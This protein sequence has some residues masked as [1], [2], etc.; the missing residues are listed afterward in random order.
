M[1]RMTFCTLALLALFTVGMAKG[2][3][4]KKKTAIDKHHN[5]ATIVKVDAKQSTVT[6]KMKDPKGKVAEKT[7]PLTLGAAYLNSDGT[8]AKLDAF[9]PG[10]HVRFTE[11]DGKIL[12]MKKRLKRTHATISK[13]DAKQGTV[14]LTMQDQGGKEASKTFAVANETV[15]LD[16]K[17]NA[18]KLDTFHMGDRVRISETHNEIVE[19]KKC[20]EQSKATITKVD[21]AK[22]TITVMLKAGTGKSTE[23]VFVL[24]EEAEY[25]DSTGEVDAVDVFKSGDDVLVIE[26]NGQLSELKQVSHN[27]QSADKQSNTKQS[28]DKS[29]T[30]ADK[31]AGAK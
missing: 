5:K 6:F 26:S 16:A 9:Q 21:A 29:Q 31:K 4:S 23:K 12:E 24:I 27:K 28:R 13:V 8:A 19:L 7:I 3:D 25:I 15:C 2:E 17:G 1:R 14:T 20:Q 30:P 18:A 11:E 10:D 22:G